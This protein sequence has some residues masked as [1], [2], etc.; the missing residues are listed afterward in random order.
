[1]IWP[2]CTILILI[3]VFGIPWANRRRK[4]E[5]RKTGDRLGFSYQKGRY[6]VEHQERDFQLRSHTKSR[7]ELGEFTSPDY[8][9]FTRITT[10]IENPKGYY[11]WL[12]STGFFGSLISIIWNHGLGLGPLRID[13]NFLMISKPKDLGERLLFIEDF[14]NQVLK[15]NLTTLR[16]RGTELFFEKKGD[17]HKKSKEYYLSLFDLLC[18]IADAVESIA[19]NESE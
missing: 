15:T 14:T 19:Q 2:W 9:P 3:L 11:L 1:M 13:E 5:I 16:V 6:S 18:D 17:L 7:G 4:R 12:K 8:I 10:P